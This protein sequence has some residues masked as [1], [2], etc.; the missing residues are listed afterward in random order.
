[1][2]IGIVEPSVGRNHNLVLLPPKVLC[3]PREGGV[4]DDE[5][6]AAVHQSQRLPGG[7]ADRLVKAWRI[8]MQRGADPGDIVREKYKG[9]FA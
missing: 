7:I 1:M 3:P 9:G 5:M 6:L 2:P 8:G 4:A